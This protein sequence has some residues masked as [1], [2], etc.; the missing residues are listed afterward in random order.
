MSWAFPILCACLQTIRVET[1]SG[2]LEAARLLEAGPT[3][4]QLES[5]NGKINIPLER[6]RVITW[7][8]SEP[9]PAAPHALFVVGLGPLPGQME[10]LDSERVTWQL[11]RGGV[12]TLRRE[13][14]RWISQIPMGFPIGNPIGI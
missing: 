11:P 12:L 7:P 8:P 3:G 9:C 2:T 14:V 13:F 5:L 1:T 10:K 4:I 6:I